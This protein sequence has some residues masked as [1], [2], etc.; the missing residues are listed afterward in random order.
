MKNHLKNI[1]IL[2]AGA[3]VG[4]IVTKIT[5]DKKKDL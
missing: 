2:A 5:E 3:A 4:T 1:G